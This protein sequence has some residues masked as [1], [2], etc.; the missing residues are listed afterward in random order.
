MQIFCFFTPCVWLLCFILQCALVE[1]GGQ[2]YTYPIQLLEGHK[3]LLREI[4][5]MENELQE[6]NRSN[7]ERDRMQG[8]LPSLYQDNFRNLFRGS[9][10]F[11]YKDSHNWNEFFIFD[12]KYLLVILKVNTETVW[13]LKITSPLFYAHCLAEFSQIK[14][15]RTGRTGRKAKKKSTSPF[16]R[17]VGEFQVELYFVPTELSFG[18]VAKSDHYLR[19]RQSGNFRPRPNIWFLIEAAQNV[20]IWFPRFEDVQLHSDFLSHITEGKQRQAYAQSVALNKASNKESLLPSYIQ[21]KTTLPP[22]YM[23][24]GTDLII[25]PNLLDKQSIN[26]V[27]LGALTSDFLVFLS[28]FPGNP[29]HV[30]GVRTTNLNTKDGIVVLIRGPISRLQNA[31]EQQ[32]TTLQQRI[33]PAEYLQPSHL[34]LSEVL[35]D[36]PPTSIRACSHHSYDDFVRIYNNTETAIDL[37][38]ATIQYVTSTGYVLKKYTFPEYILNPESFVYVVTDRAC[39]K[40]ETLEITHEDILYKETGFNFSGSKGSIVLAAD[41]R[42]VQ[43]ENNKFTGSAVVLDVLSYGATPIS[44]G[45]MPAMF[46]SDS[47]MERKTSTLTGKLI[48]TQDNHNDWECHSEVSSSLD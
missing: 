18:T 28:L 44:E 8:V 45:S 36:P 38:G 5:Q 37:N 6:P 4:K 20:T 34:L 10:D 41:H 42:K 23:I 11:V 13:F 27:E 26:Y 32:S 40:K 29:K 48:N 25:T 2:P 43:V 47:S 9:N 3:V 39:Y 21:I 33:M 19:F 31:W 17:S 46:C 1:E 22:Y 12:H 30:S 35:S 7:N 14:E 24:R 16:L 15:G